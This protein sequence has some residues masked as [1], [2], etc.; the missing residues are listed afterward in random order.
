MV[1]L[2]KIEKNHAESLMAVSVYCGGANE[3]FIFK[4]D[5]KKARALG[6]LIGADKKL[7]E[8]AY[9]LDLTSPHTAKAYSRMDPGESWDPTK[10]AWDGDDVEYDDKSRERLFELSSRGLSLHMGV[11]VG[12]K[13]AQDGQVADAVGTLLDYAR[14]SSPL[15]AHR[16]DMRDSSWDAAEPGFGFEPLEWLGAVAESSK[17]G[18]LFKEKAPENNRVAKPARSL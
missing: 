2:S 7:S 9:C 17:I 3:I 5:A 4:F 18:A 10:M 13:L 11:V 14:I 1:F 15:G 16:S 6:D 12:R 8:V